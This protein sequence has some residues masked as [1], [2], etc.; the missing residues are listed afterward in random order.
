MIRNM[1]LCIIVLT[2]CLFAANNLTIAINE[3]GSESNADMGMAAVVERG[4]WVVL[5][6]NFQEFYDQHHVEIYV[7]ADVQYDG[8][9][10]GECYVTGGDERSESTLGGPEGVIYYLGGVLDGT[11]ANLIFRDQPNVNVPGEGYGWCRI[12][13]VT[14]T[15]TTY[16]QHEEEASAQFYFNGDSS[17]ITPNCGACTDANPDC[18][19]ANNRHY[20]P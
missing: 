2:F 15:L 8:S 13:G 1:F 16:R 3:I 17:D 6:N 18:V 14:G 5:F 19:N 7:W 9:Y 10:I 12:R 4:T 11:V 20:G